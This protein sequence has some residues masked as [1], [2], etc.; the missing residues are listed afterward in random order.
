MLSAAGNAERL[1]TLVCYCGFCDAAGNCSRL[2]SNNL[3][4]EMFCHFPPCVLGQCGGGWGRWGVVTVLLIKNS[5]QFRSAFGH[6][7]KYVYTVH[8][9]NN[10]STRIIFFASSPATQV[11]LGSIKALLALLNQQWSPT[12][13]L[14][15]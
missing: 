7:M 3:A 9:A 15:I 5:Q 8:Y 2:F 10:D 11:S 1:K 12:L 13:C 6:I 4:F 14:D